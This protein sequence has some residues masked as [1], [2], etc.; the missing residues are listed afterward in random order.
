M[1]TTITKLRQDLFRLVD[2][3]LAGESLE[4]TH[5]GVRFRVVPETKPSKLSKLRQQKVVAP[6][7][8]LK[9][10]NRDLLRE[11]EAEW[12]KDWSEL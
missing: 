12:E 6:Q 8:A 3:A 9:R 2:Q 5:K 1:R 11:M 7:A 4:F 10:A